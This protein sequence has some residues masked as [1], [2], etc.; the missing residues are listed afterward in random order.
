M[1]GTK[2]SPEDWERT[3]RWLMAYQVGANSPE[4]L[5]K[6]H[7]DERLTGYDIRRIVK[8]QD[9]LLGSERGDIKLANLAGMMDM[10]PRSLFMLY[11]ADRAGLAALDFSNYPHGADV[12]QFLLDALDKAQREAPRRRRSS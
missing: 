9:P 11:Y 12:R 8:L 3:L 1:S 5:A 4:K 7:D 6:K 10:P 2:L